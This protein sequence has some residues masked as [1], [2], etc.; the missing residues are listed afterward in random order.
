MVLSEITD[1][2]P[3]ELDKEL[4]PAENYPIFASSPM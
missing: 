3:L 1:I 4:K 2:D